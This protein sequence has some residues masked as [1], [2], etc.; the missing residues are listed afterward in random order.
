MLLM[1]NLSVLSSIQLYT[2]LQSWTVKI[3][4]IRAYTVL[5]KEFHSIKLVVPNTRPEDFL[6][7]CLIASQFSPAIF[8][9]R[10]ISQEFHSS[11]GEHNPSPPPLILRGGATRL[12]R[13]VVPPLLG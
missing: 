9:C 13:G 10:I 4:D 11:L 5:P 3:Q 8:Q 6:G 1:I 12:I 2:N 7:F